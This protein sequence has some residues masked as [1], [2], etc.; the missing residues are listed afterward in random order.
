MADFTTHCI[1]RI[2][3][4]AT[5]NVYVGQSKHTQKRRAAHFQ[6]LRNRTHHSAKLQAAFNKYGEGSFY[7]EIIERDIAVEA[8]NER[9][10]CWI[11]FYD[12]FNNGY[13][14][15]PGGQD[16]GGCQAPVSG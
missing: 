11:A 2:V 6:K 10:I 3:C 9:E 12:S 13:N 1:Y 14:M 7:F 8:I 4:F 16:A 5:G 15:T